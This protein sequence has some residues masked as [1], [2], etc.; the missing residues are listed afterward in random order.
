MYDV[1]LPLFSHRLTS[2]KY[3]VDGDIDFHDPGNPSTTSCP[4]LP[5]QVVNVLE[6]PTLAVPVNDLY[7]RE[8]ALLESAVYTMDP[9]DK[10]LRPRPVRRHEEM[11]PLAGPTTARAATG[12]DR[13]KLFGATC[14]DTPL[15]TPKAN[16]ASVPENS[17]KFWKR[18]PEVSPS[19]LRSSLLAKFQRYRG[20]LPEASTESH[21]FR[22]QVKTSKEASTARR[23]P[24]G[25]TDYK[26]ASTNDLSRINELALQRP[27]FNRGSDP[28]TTPHSS[29]NPCLLGVF[30]SS[31][32][33]KPRHVGRGSHDASCTLEDLR[34]D[35]LSEAQASCPLGPLKPPRIR[36]SFAH[37]GCT[38]AQSLSLKGAMASS[39]SLLRAPQ[40]SSALETNSEH[41]GGLVS[42]KDDKTHDSHLLHDRG[43]K[44][45]QSFTGSASL[46]YCTSENF[47]PGLAST[48]NMSDV[49]SHHRLSQPETPSAS[50]Y[51]ED[52]TNASTTR[53]ALQMHKIR[54]CDDEGEI[55]GLPGMGS[56]SAATLHDETFHSFVGYNLPERKH[57][58]TPTLKRLRNKSFTSSTHDQVHSWN[59][60][61]E[62]RM[63]AMETLITDLGYLGKL[64]N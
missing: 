45:K 25:V 3:R 51:G 14:R 27:G 44:R 12:K 56:S 23:K 48:N 54:V 31:A 55:S 62:Q 11:P 53:S 29:S 37:E 6:V 52:T 57:G 42:L 19:L 61:S 59:D 49:M 21:E 15:P 33:Q 36:N 20:I 39:S 8:L 9:Q 1:N 17:W 40:T 5:G 24:F 2:S 22:R 34:Q 32:K 46:S 63:T 38:E 41:I 60:G 35:I 58:S 28:V 13:F 50:E 10:Y 7:R 16:E 43:L 47:S 64:I 30:A 26:A 18:R 4:F